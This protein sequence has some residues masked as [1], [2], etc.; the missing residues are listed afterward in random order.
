[1]HEEAADVRPRLGIAS[2]LSPYQV[3]R[4]FIWVAF[5]AF[6]LGFAGFL[7]LGGGGVALARETAAAFTPA[8]TPQ[9][10]RDAGPVRIT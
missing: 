5:A 8:S 6:V 3:F 4:P 7:A 1:M 9:Y 10:Y 2:V